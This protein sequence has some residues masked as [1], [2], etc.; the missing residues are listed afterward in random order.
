MHVKYAIIRMKQ[1]ITIVIGEEV[2]MTDTKLKNDVFDCRNRLKK[3]VN[4][5]LP[6]TPSVK[7]DEKTQ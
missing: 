7:S 1:Y 3:Q 2:F 5:Q 4:R 6:Q